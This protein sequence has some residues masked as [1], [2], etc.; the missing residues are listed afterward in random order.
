MYKKHRAFETP[1]DNCTIWRYIS[2]AKFVWL[3]AKDA[4]CFSRLDQYDD[5]WEGLLP[6]GRNIE[7]KKYIRYNK[8][9]NCWHMNNSESDAMWKL[10]GTG[11]ET[12]AIKT[13]VGRL[14]KSLEKCPID[15]FIG[16]IKYKEQNIPEGNL[17]F[18]VLYKR[19]PF[20]HEKELRLCIS[21]PLNDNPPDFTQLKEALASF[22]IDNKSDLDILKQ[23]GDKRIPATID[24]NQ[25]IDE[26]IIC[27]D[28]RHSLFDS[29][30][31]VIGDKVH[32]AKIRKSTI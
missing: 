30:K 26:V 6:R 18:P 27:P 11:G 14:I 5:W 13:N 19:T 32:N 10:Y 8:Y 3:I 21:S 2:F 4:L 29:V 7:S 9:I 16:K 24:L 31:Y 20:R 22:G 12:V 23:I 17:Y 15:V 1:P 28:S 25:L